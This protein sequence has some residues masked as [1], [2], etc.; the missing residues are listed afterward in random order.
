M[1]C[2][3]I[4]MQISHRAA[5]LAAALHTLTAAAA[6]VLPAHITGQS[7]TRWVQSAALDCAMRR[8]VRPRYHELLFFRMFSGGARKLEIQYPMS[9]I[10][11]I[12][13]LITMHSL[14]TGIRTRTRALHA[15]I[16]HQTDI[17]T[18]R[19]PR[20]LGV[21]VDAGARGAGKAQAEARRRSA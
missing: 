4:M 6:F 17:L 5:F 11:T 12:A 14:H 16:C 9:Y 2:P 8:S 13:V 10:I 19:I 1:S 15:C 3:H 20:Q 7:V 18:H 21:R